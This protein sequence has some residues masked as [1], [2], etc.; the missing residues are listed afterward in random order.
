MRENRACRFFPF[1]KPLGL[2][3]TAWMLVFSQSITVAAA[4]TTEERLES[5]R[6][7]T[8]QSNQITNWPTGPVVSA[9]AAILMEAETGA[10]LYAKNIHQKEYP[11]STTKILTCTIAA[12]R[13]Q[14][15]E[16]VT[17][18]HDAIYDTPYDSSHIAM[19]VGEKLTMEDCLNA[20]LIRSA[21]EVS[22][23]VG[24]HIAGTGE[25]E[26]FAAIMNERAKELGAINSNFVNPNGLPDENHYTTAYDLAMIGRAFFG[27]ELLCKIS[28]TKQLNIQPTEYQRDPKLENNSNLLLPGRTYAY[29]YLVG[30][31]TGYTNAARNCLV[32]CAEKDGMKLICVVFKD[33]S[34]YH[35][36]DTIALFNYGFSNFDKVKVSELETK[37]NIN[38]S[39]FYTEN[40][41]FGSSKPLL[42]LD[43]QDCIILPKTVDFEDVQSSITYE[44]D[45]KIQVAT[46]TY[47]Y[48]DVVI[49]SASVDYVRD[50]GASYDFESVDGS[51]DTA[52]PTNPTDSSQAGAESGS[53]ANTHSDA[54]TNKEKDSQKSEEKRSS[55]IYVNWTFILIGA[56]VIAIILVVVLLVR[57][58]LNSFHFSAP[59]RSGKNSS[60]WAAHSQ[61]ERDIRA[62]RKAEIKRA[63][64]R[65]K[66]KFGSNKFRDYD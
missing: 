11:A 34:P 41:I 13:C 55:F 43:T 35:Y 62:R 53:L 28:T 25:W 19:D 61:R 7:M 18:S 46:I 29:E 16:W 17:F 49:G 45:N 10:I 57:A 64:A 30:S 39:L 47:T 56:I 12:E 2:G 66:R 54:Q 20:I 4:P 8:I 26:D 37:Y 65:Q 24:E 63:K 1:I 44:G 33:E 58:Y 42:S 40:A 27:N 22:F 51:Q 52:Q 31:K 3:L 38:N 59:H 48:Q 60:N 14:L 23:A 21:N 6:A 50:A 32:T 36:E 9:E 15:D 5:Q